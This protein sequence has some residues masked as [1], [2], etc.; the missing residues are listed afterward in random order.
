MTLTLTECFETE[1]IIRRVCWEIITVFY[2][3]NAT[4]FMRL[5]VN[6]FQVQ[7]L[8]HMQHLRLFFHGHKIEIK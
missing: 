5:K 8:H 7:R 1:L 3:R 4:A 2:V 6:F